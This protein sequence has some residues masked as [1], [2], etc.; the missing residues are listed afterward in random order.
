MLFFLPRIVKVGRSL[1]GK[2]DCASEVS[3]S[4]VALTSVALDEERGPRDLPLR[5]EA[6]AWYHKALTEVDQ[7][8]LSARDVFE[9]P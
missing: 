3:E 9:R 1:L 4:K 8:S 7:E 5:L 6:T 2:R